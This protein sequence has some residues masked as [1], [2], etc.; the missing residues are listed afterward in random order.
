MTVSNDDKLNRLAH[1][2]RLCS[3]G[4]CAQCGR[5]ENSTTC[6]K[7]LLKDAAF[8]IEGVV[9]Y[10]DINDRPEA[11]SAVVHPAHYNAGKFEV[12]DVIADW[13]LDFLL[14]NVIKYVARAGR[15]GDRVEDLEKAM[16]YLQ[17]EIEHV[18]RSE[19]SGG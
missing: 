6:Y 19:I 1:E 9:K 13:G 4:D 16:Q 5:N 10:T 18:K 11:G 7:R 12:W 17:K 8:V 15:K 3:Y 2:L 14:G